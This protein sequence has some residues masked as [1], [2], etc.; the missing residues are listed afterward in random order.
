MRLLTRLLDNI[1]VSKKLGL[2]FGLVLLLT[3]FVAGMGYSGVQM[4]ID[5][6]D[7]VAIASSLTD[8]LYKAK[9]IRQDFLQT[10][11]ETDLQQFDSLV[12]KTRQTLT[13]EAK[14]YLDVADQKLISDALSALGHYENGF[15]Q[16][17]QLKTNRAELRKTWVATGNAVINNFSQVE[18]QLTQQA[19]QTG[20]WQ[21][22]IGAS[23]INQQVA[24]MRY[25]VRGYIFEPSQKNL[26]GAKQQISNIQQQG[27][28]LSVPT[29]QQT[30]LSNA[31]TALDDYTAKLD[32]LVAVDK[33]IENVKSTLDQDATVLLSSVT[34]LVDSQSAKRLADGARAKMLVI[35]V[36]VL[37]L[38]LGI[39]CSLLISSQIVNPLHLTVTAARRIADGDLTHRIGSERK[40]ELGTLLRAMG[41]MNDT[42]KDVLGQIDGSVVQLASSAEQLSAVSEQNS[43]GMQS[44]RSETDQVAT[45]INEMTASVQEV[46]GNAEQ[47]AQAAIEADTVTSTGNKKVAEAVRHIERLSA[48]IASTAEAMSELKAES[49]NI[50][51][52]LD[53]IK[54]VAEQTNLLA[55]NAAIEAARAGE[56]GRGF[57]VVA[58]EVRSLASRTQASTEEIEKLISNLQHGTQES[59]QKMDRS[60]E[61]SDEAV[62]LSRDAGNMLN[63][64]AR[65]VAKIQDM[66]HQIAAAAE[67][68]S[69]VAENINQS[70]VRVRDIAEQTAQASEET[71]Q[72]TEGVASL[73]MQLKSLLGHFK[74]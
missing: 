33:Q 47:A 66:N 21:V 4:M 51:S 67:E 19:Q 28:T 61:L 56:A 37:V 35:V 45:A 71:A 34:G 49:D 54:S 13:Q 36:S 46:A 9:I 40:D 25:Y 57:A 24:M 3:F 5:R 18:Q 7:K 27:K 48:E 64:I 58:D 14:F 29:A 52:V 16:V 42:L 10:G 39:G 68:Q 22:V 12:E 70:V 60:R 11:N 8:T 41:E 63:D 1:A 43:A 50:G 44:Q 31:L 26:D 53:V 69:A 6:S 74:L 62:G 32:Q 73:G 30:L 65:A 55:L 2:G 15:N 17:K 59:V 72:A 23:Q 20:D 38:L